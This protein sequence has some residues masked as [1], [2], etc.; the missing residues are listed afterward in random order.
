TVG[1]LRF[2]AR[3]S[4][5]ATARAGDRTVRTL[6]NAAVAVDPRPEAPRPA[7]PDSVTRGGGRRRT[8]CTQRSSGWNAGRSCSTWRA[9]RWA[10]SSVSR[11]P[12]W[13]RPTPVLALLLYATFLG[14]PIVGI[15]RAFRYWRYLATRLSIY[16][17]MAQTSA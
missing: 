10:R 5:D 8:E 15:G 7:L 6:V 17:G 16:I 4:M 3:S 12:R 2:S 13:P 9:W 11:S 14:G 1:I